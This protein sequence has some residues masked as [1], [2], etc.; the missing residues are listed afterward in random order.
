M[1]QL[2][3][4][5]LFGALLFQVTGQQ[6]FVAATRR[7]LARIEDLFGGHLPAPTELLAVDPGKL[8]DDELIAELTQFRGRPVDRAGFPF[9]SRSAEKTSSCRAN[10]AL[11]K[12]I[13]AAYH[14]DHFPTRPELSALP[15]FILQEGSR[16]ASATVE[17]VGAGLGMVVASSPSEYDVTIV[18]AGP[19]GLAGAVDAASEGLRTVVIEA[20]APGG[21]AGTTFMIENYLGVPNGISGSELATR[22]VVQARRFGAD[23]FEHLLPREQQLVHVPEPAL[24]RSGLSLGRR[25]EGMRVDAGQRKCR[26][27]HMFR[28]SWATAWWLRA[29][30]AGSAVQKPT[31]WRMRTTW[32]R[33]G[34]SWWISRI[35][36]TWLCWP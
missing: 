9:S 24:Q 2:P 25:G 23:V 6:L 4:M 16:L 36:P 11:R 15:L 10:L 22:A 28:P 3:P 12:A 30:L 19:A 21:Q 17:Q 34:S 35:F 5:D 1:A 29:D 26:N 31:C 33:S 27:A 14:L 20:V 18:G 7:T 8:P 13:R 32:M